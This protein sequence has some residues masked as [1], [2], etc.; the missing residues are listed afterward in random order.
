M[1][2]Q[3]VNRVIP[4]GPVGIMHAVHVFNDWGQC[5]SDY[6]SQYYWGQG[7][8]YLTLPDDGAG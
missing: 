7:T 3:G 5:Y 2:G 4:I 6:L 8:L 1:K